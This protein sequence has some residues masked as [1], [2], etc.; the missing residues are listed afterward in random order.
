MFELKIDIL[1]VCMSGIIAVDVKCV[2]INFKLQN[3]DF[4]RLNLCWLNQ[5]ESFK[6]HLHN[7]SLSI[8]HLPFESLLPH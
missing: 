6:P 8:F 7:A 3:I 4:H 5:A 2:I 1:D